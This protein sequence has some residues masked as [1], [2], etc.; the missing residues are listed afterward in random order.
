M[1]CGNVKKGMERKKMKNEKSEKEKN[2]MEKGFIFTSDALIT[3]P[4][5]ILLLTS[6]LALSSI[7]QEDLF[8]YEYVYTVAK[9]Q[10]NYL[11]ELPYEEGLSVLQK[12]TEYISK[13][14]IKNAA[15]LINKSI[16]LREDF[17]YVIEYWDGKK[18]Q[19]L[20]SK[21]KENY[22][23]SASAIKITIGMKNPKITVSGKEIDIYNTNYDEN[24]LEG[25]D[26]K[27]KVACGI[28][29]SLY[30]KGKIVGP[31]MFRIRIQK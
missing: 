28:Q 18:W 7:L 11:N 15:D 25:Y 21:E 6:F 26:C 8:M 16:S 5:T 29:T 10:I 22:R 24:Y 20:V 9:D 12:A 19:Q 27:S 4:I 3:I 31:M 23:F 2:E 13:N 30:D 17:G 14:E 1:I